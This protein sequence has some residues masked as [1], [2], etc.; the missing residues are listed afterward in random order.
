MQVI[1]LLPIEMETPF[2]CA[3]KVLRRIPRLL[4]LLGY[5]CSAYFLKER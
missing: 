3:L 2:I 5:Q 4:P 1:Y